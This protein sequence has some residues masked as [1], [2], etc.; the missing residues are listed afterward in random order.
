MNNQKINL[1]SNN[2]IKGKCILSMLKYYCP[3]KNTCIDYMHSILHGVIKTLFH[4]WF[5]QKYS[6]E[7]FSLRKNIQEID[8]LLVMI[9]PPF[10]S[11]CSTI[12]SGLFKLARKRVFIIYYLLFSSCLFPNNAG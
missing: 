6:S 9:K 3:V 10:F 4:F 2:G 5:D 12:Y 11:M 7:Q 8:K 1:H